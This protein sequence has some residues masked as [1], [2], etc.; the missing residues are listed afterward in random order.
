MLKVD[1][2]VAGGTP[3]D[4]E[5]LARRLWVRLGNGIELPIHPPEDILL[6]KLRW[7]QLGGGVSDR[8]WRDIVGIVRVQGRRLDLP[9]LQRQAPAIGV[10]EL[11][12]RALAQGADEA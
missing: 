10:T 2:F 7:F 4:A 1:I 11:L 9:Y 12:G 3:L 8:Q 6:Q 5:Q